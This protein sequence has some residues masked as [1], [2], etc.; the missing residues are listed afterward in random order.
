MRKNGLEKPKPTTSN[1]N[2]IISI[3]PFSRIQ[4]YPFNQKG[5]TETTSYRNTHKDCNF[6]RNQSY[7][8]SN[9]NNNN[10]DKT[11]I[12]TE[13]HKDCIFLK[14][15]RYPFH[16]KAEIMRIEENKK[17]PIQRNLPARRRYERE[18]RREK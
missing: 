8:F 7:P 9:N 1:T 18:E 16:E 17:H 10:K 12:S 3:F 11:W 13:T 5:N 2:P 14:K 6:S 15:I 4:K